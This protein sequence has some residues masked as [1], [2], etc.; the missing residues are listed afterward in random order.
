MVKERIQK[1][2]AYAGIASR[3]KAEE[4]IRDGLVTVNGKRAVIGMK[5][6]PLKDYI[7]VNNK[8][9]TR[10]E[11]LVYIMF[12]KPQ[13][14]ITSMYDPEGRVTVKDYLRKV[15]Q[16]V[17]P[18]GRLDYDAEGLLIITNDGEFANKILHPSNKIKKTYL[19]KLKGII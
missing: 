19:V 1:F 18:V 3:R 16:R 5:V 11:P 7:K 9:I 12:N 2:I 8:L 4:L 10:N 17:Y 6:D 14:C 13:H 15:K